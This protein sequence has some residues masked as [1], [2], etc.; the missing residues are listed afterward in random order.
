MMNSKGYQIRLE[1]YKENV[2]NTGIMFAKGDEQAYG[3][4]IRLTSRGKPYKIAENTFAYLNW[5]KPNGEIDRNEGVFTSHED[6]T[7]EYEIQ[8]EEIATVGIGEV[9]LELE[10]EGS[11]LTW[12]SF[13]YRVYDALNI[14]PVSG[15]TSN[16]PWLGPINQSLAKK[17][18]IANVANNLTTEVEGYALGARQGGVLGAKTNWMELWTGT[19][20]V[21]GNATIPGLGDW[22]QICV[23]TGAPATNIVL[24]MFGTPLRGSIGYGSGNQIIVGAELGVAGNALT[25]NSCS[26]VTHI[27]NSNHSTADNTVVG[28]YG[29]IKR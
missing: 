4:S 26:T 15:A 6:G 25:L 3:L 24:V 1:Q 2:Q 19:L 23:R 8:Q 28:I 29:M 20:S 14:S 13:T 7:V 22:R 9:V 12:P 21:G 17:L 16:E 11:R 27:N 18:P 10:G 5:K